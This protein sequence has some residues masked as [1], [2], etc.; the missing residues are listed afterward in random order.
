MI[1]Q[2]AISAKPTFDGR[3]ENKNNRV[4]SCSFSR[5]VRSFF[6]GEEGT[7]VGLAIGAAGTHPAALYEDQLIVDRPR[8]REL[9]VFGEDVDV[10]GDERKVHGVSSAFAAQRLKLTGADR[11]REEY[12]S[13]NTAA[14]TGTQG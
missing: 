12:S 7:V 2:T 9:A 6:R 14:R 5:G 13:R 3:H 11:R 8:Y 1:F 4:D 10:Y